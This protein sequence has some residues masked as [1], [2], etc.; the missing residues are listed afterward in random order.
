MKINNIHFQSEQ[1]NQ[2]GVH[3]VQTRPTVHLYGNLEA[4]AKDFRFAH[5][6]LIGKDVTFIVVTTSE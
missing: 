2:D 5:K 3:A 6:Y 4:A 1:P